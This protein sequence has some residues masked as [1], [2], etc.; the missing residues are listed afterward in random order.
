MSVK[1]KIVVTMINL[2]CLLATLAFP[3]DTTPFAVL[4][5]IVSVATW[6]FHTYEDKKTAKA[7]LIWYIVGVSM[8]AMISVLLGVAA[9]IKMVDKNGIILNELNDSFHHYVFAIKPGAF[10]GSGESF[11]Y[12]TV[13]L[14]AFFLV[15]VFSIVEIIATLQE[16]KAES[17]KIN[18]PHIEPIS[19]TIQNQIGHL[20]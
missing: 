3:N 4:I 10:V 1:V 18:N 6:A 13:A 7:G 11:G 17:R 14:T 2:A 20:R 15:A 9:N 12:T 16:N 5:T 19:V 8:I